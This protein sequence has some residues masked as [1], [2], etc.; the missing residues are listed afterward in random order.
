M[1]TWLHFKTLLVAMLCIPLNDSPI[2][3]IYI[4]MIRTGFLFKNS[5][6]GSMVNKTWLPLEYCFQCSL[7]FEVKSWIWRVNFEVCFLSTGRSQSWQKNSRKIGK[8]G[9]LRAT[10]TSFGGGSRPAQGSG[11]GRAPPRDP[12][13]VAF[14]PPR[15]DFGVARKPPLR[16][17]G[18]RATTP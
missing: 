1:N 11:G 17:K 15:V 4:Y 5:E 12:L 13:G 10:P 7:N 16:L 6:P 14:D 2:F 8:L 9:G 18:G 3:Y